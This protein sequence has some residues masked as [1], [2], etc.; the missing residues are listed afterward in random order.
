MQIPHT[1]YKDSKQK[2]K[3]SAT[4]YEAEELD[5]T[6]AMHVGLGDEEAS[7]RAQRRLEEMKVPL[8]KRIAKQNADDSGVKI[9]VEGG[10]K[11]ATFIPRDA[12]KKMEAEAKRRHESG[13]LRGKRKRRGVQELHL[14]AP[15][16]YKHNK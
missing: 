9:R 13:E 16:K 5:A 10:S 12:R 14:K 6:T 11:E 3:K 2:K 4:V 15:F 8:T 1:F 7:K